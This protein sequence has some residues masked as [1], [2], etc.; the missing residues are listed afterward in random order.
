MLIWRVS[1]GQSVSLK[2]SEICWITLEDVDNSDEKHTE[3]EE[4]L[5]EP[6]AMKFT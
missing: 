2:M 6:L 5:M 3:E 4:V 1:W